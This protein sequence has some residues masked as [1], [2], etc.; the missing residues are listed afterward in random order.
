[1]GYDP[2]GTPWGYTEW[3]AV[4]DGGGPGARAACKS[5]RGGR[6]RRPPGRPARGD[7]R[8]REAREVEA[9]SE[10]WEAESQTPDS[11]DAG[12]FRHSGRRG[13][14]AHWRVLSPG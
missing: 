3:A 2:R 7:R 10:A 14:A 4:V 1:M 5:P 12:R 13:G 8:G 6:P 11:D 9:A